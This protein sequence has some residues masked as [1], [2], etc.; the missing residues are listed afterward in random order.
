MITSSAIRQLGSGFQGELI[1]PGAPGYDGA[2]A[3]FN[4]SIDRHPA[5][6][7]RCFGA[8]DVAR[9][10]LFAREHN[11]PLA[12]RGTGHNV[13]GY[14]VCDDGVVV[15]LLPMKAIA[16]DPSARTVRAQGGCN[17]GEVNDALQPHAPGRV[18]ARVQHWRH[19]QSAARQSA[20]RPRLHSPKDRIARDG[21]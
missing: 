9:A 8:D 3:V 11:L 1:Q 4:V 21:S 6:I 7:A 10:V 2:R 5:L 17:W 16:V 12:V 19:W 13:A 15:D 20:D 14:A 18:G